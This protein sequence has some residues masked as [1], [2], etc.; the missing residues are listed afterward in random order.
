MKTSD[1]PPPLCT[2]EDWTTSPYLASDYRSKVL[3]EIVHSI[4]LTDSVTEDF[5]WDVQSVLERVNENI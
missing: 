2:P 5:V 3:G 4:W 1:L